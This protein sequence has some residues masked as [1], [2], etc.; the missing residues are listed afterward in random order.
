M[1]GEE[2]HK[3]LMPELGKLGLDS[4][5]IANS[6]SID[7]NFYY[8]SGGM[9]FEGAFLILEQFPKAIVPNFEFER[10]KGESWIPD[11]EKASSENFLEN[12][13]AWLKGKKVG[14]NGKLMSHQLWKKLEREDIEL[15]DVSETLEKLRMVKN[16]KEV[17]YLK[18]AAEITKKVFK[19]VDFEKT[20]LELAADF[21]YELKRNDADCAYDPVIAYDERSALPHAKAT[22]AKGSKVLLVDMGARYKGYNVDVTR[23]FK[24]KNDIELELIYSTVQEAQEMAIDAIRQDM[25]ASEVDSIVRDYLVGAGHV[26]PHATG[27]GIGLNVHEIPY[28]GMKSDTV[29]KAGMVFTVEPGIYLG[30]KFG[31]RIEDTVLVTSRGCEVLTQ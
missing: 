7:P 29:L 22:T 24:L 1:Y 28:I 4:V 5:L 31:V 6:E 15:H 27:H 17:E 23:S 18:K 13:S 21:V 19:K 10:F 11:V 30:G 14:V 26:F 8:F 25:K 12:I 20:E 3:K 16:R 9:G 2:Q